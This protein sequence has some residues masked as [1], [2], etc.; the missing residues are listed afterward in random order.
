MTRETISV[1]KC[2]F[3]ICHDDPTSLESFAKL[4]RDQK[5][6]NFFFEKKGKNMLKRIVETR[7]D[8]IYMNYDTE[9][10]H[11]LNTV[12]M[13][14]FGYAGKNP[15]LPVIFSSSQPKNPTHI[16]PALHSGID[17]II[18]APISRPNLAQQI[19]AIVDNRPPYVVSHD[20]IG[21]KRNLPFFNSP[22]RKFS[23]PIEIP[24]VFAIKAKGKKISNE[25]IKKMIKNTN[26][27][28]NKEILKERAKFIRELIQ[29]LTLILSEEKDFYNENDNKAREINL[30]RLYDSTLVSKQRIKDSSF[31]HVVSM[32][33]SIIKVIESIRKEK[34]PFNERQIN[35]MQHTAS[36][37]IQAF[38]DD[39][40][41][42]E[43][44]FDI[45]K[46]VDAYAQ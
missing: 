37:I 14:R 10:K 15:Y 16:L 9:S 45:T 20:Y 19:I 5:I 6:T 22:E 27:N 29:N 13:L 1:N 32:Y 11:C 44:A 39:K 28:V 46:A 30:K 18:P 35:L 3:L 4:I 12:N 38:S 2:R 42:K 40:N 33:E 8:I 17:M 24:N 26:L 25:E 43:T 36:A 23:E 31:E 7:P 34:L 21:P 41:I